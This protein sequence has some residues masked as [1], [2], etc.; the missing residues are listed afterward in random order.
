MSI[1]HSWDGSVLTVTS[2]S[3][4]SSADLRGPKGDTGPRG[5]QGPGGILYNTDNEPLLDLSE[6]YTRAEVD[7][8]VANADGADVD[9]SNYYTKLEVNDKIANLELEADLSSYYTKSEVDELVENVEVDL[10]DYPTRSEVDG[11]VNE[12]TEGHVTKS[13]VDAEIAKAQME[14]ADIDTSQFV[15]RE[16]LDN[17]DID[18]DTSEFVTRDELNNLQI[19]VEVD[20]ETI[21]RGP[22]GLQ[23][24]I[25]GGI[26]NPYIIAAEGLSVSLAAKAS[27]IKV[28]N[29]EKVYDFNGIDTY[30]FRFVFEDGVV[31]SY[32]A[33]FELR[34]T[35][36]GVVSRFDA[37]FSGTGRISQFIYINDK[38][39]ALANSFWV[40]AGSGAT[41]AALT[42]AYVWTGELNEYE[43]IKAD[44]IPVDNE[45]IVINNGKLT[46]LAGGTV[47]AG[48]KITYGT[49]DLTP[50]V[51]VLETGTLYVV[52]E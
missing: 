5:P 7:E 50:G 30:E 19:G 13:Y 26:K 43:P 6:Y 49:T 34:A 4:V 1:T 15:T 48:S 38:A 25:G 37:D 2:D 45:T 44:F 12:A 27:M 31:E 23:T 17:L 24:V 22:N 41:S 16:E 42:G 36:S 29:A 33:T 39:T 3:G 9:L 32:S 40:V 21:I 20:G 18:I 14:G 52:Y 11:L 8:L 47:T 35:S 46:A 10:S 51:S 28:M